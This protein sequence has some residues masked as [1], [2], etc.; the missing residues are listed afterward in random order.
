MYECTRVLPHRLQHGYRSQEH[1][2]AMRI[3]EWTD[4]MS[5]VSYFVLTVTEQLRVIL[6]TLLFDSVS[7]TVF[8][9]CV[10]TEVGS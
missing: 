9:L 4:N 6:N 2:G 7:Q 3:E 1:R 10:T 5:F 8:F